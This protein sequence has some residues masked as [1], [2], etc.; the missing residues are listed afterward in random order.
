MK[1][2][3]IWIAYSMMWISV[4]LAV[5]VAVYITKSAAP[6]WTFLIPAMIRVS[7]DDNKK[8]CLIYV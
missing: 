5:S 8:E 1:S 7:S 4:S 3:L 6:L 2:K